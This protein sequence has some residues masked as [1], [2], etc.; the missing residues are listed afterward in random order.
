MPRKGLPGPANNAPTP[1]NSIPTLI[2]D[3][4]PKTS[5]KAAAPEGSSFSLM[6]T[7][8][9]EPLTRCQDATRRSPRLSI[10]PSKLSTQ[11]LSSS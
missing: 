6:L 4:V 7:L 9:G 11:S 3:V 8:R 2:G 5:S 1:T 10:H